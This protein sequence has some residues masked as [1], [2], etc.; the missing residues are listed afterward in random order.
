[1]IRS[2]RGR[3]S[4]VF[5]AALQMLIGG[6][7]INPATGTVDFMLV[8]TEEEAEIGRKTHPQVLAEFGGVY[9]DP[10]LATYVEQVGNRIVAITEL[11]DFEYR[12]TVLDSPTVNAFAVSGG[13][14]YVTRG[15]LALLS[16]EA[17]LAGVLSHELA[18]INARHGAQRLSGMKAEDRL[19]AAFGC[20]FE[21]PVLGDTAAV[22]IRLAFGG[23]SQDQELEADELGL[24]YLTAAGYDSRGMTD[25]LRKLEAQRDLDARV[26]GLG[27]PR[28]DSHGYASTHPLTGARIEQVAGLI[29]G[30]GRSG[31]MLGVTVYLNAIDGLLYGNRQEYG[32][33]IGRTYAHPIRRVTFTV[34]PGYAMYADSHRVTALGPDGA[35]ILFE[36]SRRLITGSV[37]EYLTNIWAEGL[38]LADVRGFQINGLDAATGWLR[39]EDQQHPMDYRLVAVRAGTGTIYRFLF[40]VPA[41]SSAHASEDLRKATYSFRTLDEDEAASLRPRR[42]RIITAAQGDTLES[43]VPLNKFA[44][45]ARERFSILNGLGPAAA[46]EPGQPVK[47]VRY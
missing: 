39:S 24:R 10:A 1:M 23:F 16:S 27:A 22:G 31:G 41:Q 29:E 18:H 40:L 37:T 14:V 15:L 8:S 9:Y 6:C 4:A 46:L 32:F 20:D 33:V 7:A 21:V 5:A 47:L 17:E 44:D 36:P 34:P 25:F 35:A 45:H 30:A 43:I 26:A 2:C 28:K 38:P 12:F 3:V 42:V 13:Y 11:Q 19:C